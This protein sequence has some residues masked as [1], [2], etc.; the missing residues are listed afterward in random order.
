MQD[1]ARP[2]SLD[3]TRLIS[4]SWT[5]RHP[6][7]IDRVCYAYLDYFRDKALAVIQHRGVVRRLN[8]ER[9]DQ[10]FDLLQEPAGRFR[11]A[12]APIFP[13]LLMERETAPPAAPSTY[14]N[15]SHTDFDLDGHYKWIDRANVQSVYFIHDLIPI[16]HPHL[17]R[18][19]AVKRHS[20]RVH[21]ALRN[22]D[23]IVVGS[24][25]VAGELEAFAAD[26]ELDMPP[27]LTVPLAGTAMPTNGGEGDG[28]RPFFLCVGTIE[29]R[30]NHHLLFDVWR[31]LSVRL[32]QSAPRLVIVGQSGPLSAEILS[33]LNRDPVLSNSVDL[34][35]DCNDDQLARLMARAQAVLMPS[36]A[37]GYGLPVVEALAAGTAVIAS[38]IPIFREIGQGIALLL[39]PEDRAGW[40]RA[41]E[42]YAN[43]SGD[44]K[45]RQQAAL[46][47]FKPP[48]WADHFACLEQWLCKRGESD[49]QCL[50]V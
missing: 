35:S 19:Q 40:E 24:Q 44:D 1:C 21:M 43:G 12:F 6:T 10:L 31:K 3:V 13:R 15:V 47:Q 20:A 37:E 49:G 34:I 50:N 17:T 33:R 45:Q 32:G 38:D 18:P 41:I 36:L 16:L 11:L 48:E 14:I 8:A 39:D 29:P 23:R 42:Q 26:S 27:I 7:G 22:A 2:Y 9:S 30:K 5:R 28:A 46:S 4:R 25:S